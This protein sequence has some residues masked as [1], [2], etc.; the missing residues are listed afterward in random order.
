MSKRQILGALTILFVLGLV[1]GLAQLFAEAYLTRVLITIAIYAILS[2]SLGVSNGFTGVFSIG[3]VSFMALGAY[4]AGIL[5]LPLQ[6]KAT[7]MEDLPGFLGTIQIGFLPATLAAGLVPAIVALL[8]GAAILRL[9]GHYIA[10][11]TLGLLVITSEVLQNAEALTRGARTFTGVLPLTN[12]GWVFFWAVITLYV[13]WRLKRSHFGRQMLASR[14]DLA[15]AQAQGINILRTRLLA[16]VVSAFFTGVAGSLYAHFVLA[17]SSRTFYLPITFEVIS[18]LVVGGMGSVSGAFL[19]AVALG[20]LKEVMRLLEPGFAIG[21]IHV[22]P[23]YG[24]AQIV[25][26]T[27]FILV[28]IFRPK[29]VLGDREI[30]PLFWMRWLKRQDD[31]ARL[32]SQ[33]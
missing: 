26:A 17:F 32:K 6:V 28:M 29:G 4:T 19:G 1:F 21:P 3:H 18:M 2:V 20:S 25:I 15:A 13:A 22:P 9:S 10:V 11:A 14:D 33:M 27:L 24:L 16:F 8:V 30:D 7:T 31:G 23:V 5:T 12:L